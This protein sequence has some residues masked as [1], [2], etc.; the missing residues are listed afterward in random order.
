AGLGLG[1]IVSSLEL[2]VSVTM[3]FVLLGEKVLLIQWGGIIL[4]LFAIVLMN[5]PSKKE[6]KVV[7][8]V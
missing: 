2:P 5:L 1:S 6:L 3:A 7:E 8:A 4:I